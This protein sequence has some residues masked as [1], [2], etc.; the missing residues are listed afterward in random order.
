MSI[1]H[2]V[3]LSV[4]TQPAPE[5]TSAP[6]AQSTPAASARPTAA[7]GMPGEAASTSGGAASGSGAITQQS[8]GGNSATP[9]QQGPMGGI[10]WVLPAML[11][12]MVVMSFVAGRKDKKKREELMKSLQRGDKV[13]TTGGMIGHIA[14][15]SDNEAVLRMEDGRVRIVRSAIQSVLESKR[16]GAAIEAKPEAKAAV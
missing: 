6:A 9:V 4:M 13:M 10:F 16:G 14:E 5:S 7:A 1:E 12:V 3:I 8:G 11:V 2:V 15:L